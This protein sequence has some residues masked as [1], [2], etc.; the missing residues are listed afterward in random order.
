[1]DAY[2]ILEILPEKIKKKEWE[3]LFL[4]TLELIKAYPFSRKEF[5]DIHGLKVQ[6]ILPVKEGKNYWEISGDFKSMKSAG[7]FVMFK[8]LDHYI[9]HSSKRIYLSKEKPK[10]RKELGS[11]EELESGEDLKLGENSASGKKLEI[12]ENIE[13]R[14]N[15][16]D[17]LKYR[18]QNKNLVPLFYAN[19]RGYTYHP[20]ILAIC[21][22][23]E[24]RLSGS[25][26]LRGTFDYMQAQ[27]AIDWANSILDNPADLP[28]I[29]NYGKLYN[30][31]KEIS[32]GRVPIADFHY[33]A[34][35]EKRMYE[36]LKDNFEEKEIFDL[37]KNL[38]KKYN[39]ATE[40][41]N[42]CIMI[43]FLN[44]GY[45]IDSLCNISC[46]HDDGPRFKEEDFVK[47]L[48]STWISIPDEKR[49]AIDVLVVPKDYPDTVYGFLGKAP[50]AMCSLSGMNI[51]KYISKDEV[52]SILKLKFPGLDKI[53]FII[54][55]EM[56]MTVNTLDEI[57]VHRNKLKKKLQDFEELN[58]ISDVDCCICWKE[59]MNLSEELKTLM[60]TARDLIDG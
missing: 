26:I 19:T 30:R 34:H 49:K 45:S 52:S 22:L 9:R 35:K 4:E 7:T 47:A 50:M 2:L 41:N 53:D 54:E 40:T 60:K 56:E 23:I 3:D 36:Y 46:F 15:N 17:I 14:E 55:G 24:Q 25:A 59:G 33:I 6:A 11:G 18:L 29:V 42:I 27:K 37:F 5:M 8:N 28:I 20:Y 12:G 31:L 44:M 48:C 38:M 1:M 32:S 51:E 10:P 57:I 21:C 43:D 39:S 58:T 13:S 16:E